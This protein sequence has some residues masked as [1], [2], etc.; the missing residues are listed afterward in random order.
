MWAQPTARSS[1]R[2]GRGPMNGSQA[3]DPAGAGGCSPGRRYGAGE[4][5]Q[6]LGAGVDAG[7]DGVH[8]EKLSMNTDT[9]LTA[10]TG[11]TARA[12]SPRP[13]LG[14]RSVWP[15]ASRA[16]PSG[17]ARRSRRRRGLG[18][19]GVDL[20]MA[21]PPRTI[22]HLLHG[23]G[24]PGPRGRPGGGRRRRPPAPTMSAGV[25]PPG[26]CTCAAPDQLGDC[27]RAAGRPCSTAVS[28]PGPGRSP[29][30]PTTATRRG[31][32]PP[33]GRPSGQ[34]LPA[35]CVAGASS[36]SIRRTRG[37]R[38]QH[39]VDDDGERGAVLQQVEGLGQ[40][41]LVMPF[42]RRGYFS[43]HVPGVLAAHL[44]D[45]MA[46]GRLIADYIRHVQGL[47]R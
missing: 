7:D 37:F 39:G 2:W 5:H 14:R 17:P 40:A 6:V 8:V 43:C 35:R 27:V 11:A 13:A 16:H 9:P 30:A 20:R 3:G 45:G 21:Q 41:R 18:G 31:P 12:V 22:S 46:A 33:P 38:P 32:C 23:R 34:A 44:G 4:G 36:R 24:G 25:P 28:G 15:G 10:V 47:C 1:P 42:T 19:R 26:S 29:P